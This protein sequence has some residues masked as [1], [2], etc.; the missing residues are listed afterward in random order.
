MLQ[1]APGEIL[2]VHLAAALAAGDA[3]AGGPACAQQASRAEFSSWNL[4]VFAPS[5]FGLTHSDACT[6]LTVITT[7][8]CRRLWN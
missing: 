4:S 7:L 2:V 6:V 3:A 1:L 5:L 8:F